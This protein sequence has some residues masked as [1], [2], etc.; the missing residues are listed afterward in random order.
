MASLRDLTAAKDSST[1]RSA[2]QV[3]G[4]VALRYRQLQSVA[5][6]LVDFISACEHSPVPA[7]LALEEAT[8]KLGD[9]QLVTSGLA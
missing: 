1:A 3:L 7:A 9:S 4:A 2:G 6:T 5:A 8:L